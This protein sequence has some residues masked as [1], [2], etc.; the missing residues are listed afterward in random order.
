MRAVICSTVSLARRVDTQSGRTVGKHDCRNTQPCN[1]IC[2]SGCSGYDAAGRAHYRIVA[3]I[4]TGHSGADDQMSLL[5]K[6]HGGNHVV[7]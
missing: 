1:R 7:D 3:I 4:D 2:R 6:S 5:L